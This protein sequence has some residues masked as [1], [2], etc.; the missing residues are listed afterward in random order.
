MFFGF[1]IPRKCCKC[2]LVLKLDGWEESTGVKAE[3]KIAESLG[4]PVEYVD[5]DDDLR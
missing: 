5:Y 3:I 1:L 2:V 4:I